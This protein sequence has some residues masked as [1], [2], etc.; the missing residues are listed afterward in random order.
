MKKIYFGLV[1]FI[2][3]FLFGCIKVNAASVSVSSNSSNIIVGNNFTVTVSVS[4]DVEAWDFSIGYDTSK[5][6]VV[7]SSLESGMRSASLATLHSRSYSITLK[8]LLQVRH[9]SMLMMHHYII[10]E[11]LLYQH[12]KDRKN[13][14]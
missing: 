7:S 14:L 13:L 9:Q 12:L 5:L 3:C 6:R 10:Q 8:L 1:L 11:E 4:S 2:S